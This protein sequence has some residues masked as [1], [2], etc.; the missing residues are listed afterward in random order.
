MAKLRGGSKKLD[1]LWAPWR[2][3]YVSNK[4]ESGCLFCKI[5]KQKNDKKNQIVFRSS[6]CF[7]V[8]NRYPYNNGHLLIA[9]YKHTSKLEELNEKEILDI[10]KVLIKIKKMLTKILNPN[11]F[12]IGFNIGEDAGA[13]IVDHIHLHLV[14]R[15][16]GDTNFMPVLSETKIISESLTDLYQKLTRKNK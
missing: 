4:K 8:L 7:A 15:W 14:P 11:G 3:K 12:N 10:H 9:P 16:K 1:K 13:G 6:F 5:N 2:I